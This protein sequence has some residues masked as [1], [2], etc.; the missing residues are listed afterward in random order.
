MPACYVWKCDCGIEW[1]VFRSPNEEKQ[2][3]TCMC[4]R[5]HELTGVVTHLFYLPDPKL[6]INQD[7]NE[8]PKSQIEECLSGA[9]LSEKGH[10]ANLKLA[11]SV[12]ITDLEL[13]MRR[14][15]IFM[16]S[17]REPDLTIDPEVILSRKDQ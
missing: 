7:W 12:Q 10:S 8:V 6:T 16:L 14:L 2:I 13:V 17:D 5:R 4:K 3:H 11:L 9:R 15:T 1:K